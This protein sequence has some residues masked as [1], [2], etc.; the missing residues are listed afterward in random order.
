VGA[1]CNIKDVVSNARRVADFVGKTLESGNN[2]IVLG[3]NC[4]NGVGA[5]AVVMATLQ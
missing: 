4:T 3:G 5:I 1:H 2:Y